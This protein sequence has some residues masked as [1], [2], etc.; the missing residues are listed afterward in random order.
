MPTTLKA[1]KLELF[2][3]RVSAHFLTAFF[4]LGWVVCARFIPAPLPTASAEEITAFYVGNEA[5][6]RVGVTLMMLS[7]GPW[8]AWGAVL[9]AWTRRVET[10]TPVLAYIQIA[11]FTISEMIGVAC[12]LLWGIAS[13]RAGHIAPEITL[14]LNDMAWLMFLLPWPPFSAWCIAVGIAVLRDESPRPV[15]PRWVA[16]MSFLT[17]FLYM[18][19]LLPLFFKTGGFAYNGL[20]GMYLPLL[21]FFVWVEGV[22]FPMA[23]TLKQQIRQLERQPGAVDSLRASNV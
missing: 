21:I 14:T 19:A 5:G 1:L 2:C 13:F 11:S 10:G 22:T 15:L 16:G 17:A 6:I 23:R 20:L 4:A 3:L 12:A 18:P 9:A 7:F 8:A